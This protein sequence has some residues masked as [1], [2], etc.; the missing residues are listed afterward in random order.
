M[1]ITMRRPSKG[2]AHTRGLLAC[3]LWSGRKSTLAPFSRNKRPGPP[4]GGEVTGA[5]T[6]SHVSMQVH[7]S[8]VL[9]GKQ[10]SE[11]PNDCFSLSP[12]YFSA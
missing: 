9:V 3:C 2:D 11:L 6:W 7:F 8:P 4:K 5:L 12:Y 10:L 1:T